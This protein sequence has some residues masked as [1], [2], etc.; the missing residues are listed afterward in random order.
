MGGEAALEALLAERAAAGEDGEPLSLERLLAIFPFPLDGF[1]KRSVEAL[2]E[3]KSVVV[4]A[5]TGAARV[6]GGRATAGRWDGVVVENSAAHAC[7]MRCSVLLASIG[8]LPCCG[9]ESLQREW[10]GTVAYTALRPRTAGAGKT[11]IAEA[12]A[13]AALARGQRVIYTTPLKALSNQKLFEMRKRFGHSRC[14]LQTGDASLNTE[15][16]IVV[17]TTEI[18][19]NIMYRTAEAAEPSATGAA[20]SELLPCLRPWCCVR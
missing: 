4:C 2:L 19:R 3:G 11:A 13:A 12:A 14:G 17:M 16:D 20:A 18:L 8:W 6:A 5:P 1:Q 9:F 7:D 10:A 15:A